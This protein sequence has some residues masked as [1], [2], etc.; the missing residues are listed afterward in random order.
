VTSPHVPPA[1]AGSSRLLFAIDT[2]RLPPGPSTVEVGAGDGRF[3][4]DFA[5]WLERMD[6]EL[7]ARADVT[8]V[9][10]VG[11]GPRAIRGRG[12]APAPRILALGGRAPEGS[13][14]GIFSSEP[15]TR[16]R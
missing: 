14:A 7:S 4:A 10:G 2:D 13:V 5:R 11:R 6:P 15:T 16:S 12:I 9:K 3:L 1:F 8:A